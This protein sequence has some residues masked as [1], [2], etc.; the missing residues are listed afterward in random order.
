[1]DILFKGCTVDACDIHFA[2]LF[3]NPGMNDSP[4]VPT[5]NG[6]PR[7]QSGANGFR[8]S[9]REVGNAY[10]PSILWLPFF[11]NLLV[12]FILPKLG[13]F[14]ELQPEKKKKNAPKKKEH[15]HGF[16]SKNPL[17]SSGVGCGSLFRVGTP[18]LVLKAKPTERPEPIWW[19]WV[20]GMNR[21]GFRK[22]GNHNGFLS[23][24]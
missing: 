16:L 19:V 14:T 11:G 7:F 21:W 24:W 3:R 18:F 13:S 12:C 23:C 20:S 6:F 5:S 8:P 17:L 22:K 10:K 4:N 2:P 15:I 1:M 9:V